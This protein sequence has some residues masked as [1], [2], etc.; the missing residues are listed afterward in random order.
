MQ[1]DEA[2]VGAAFKWT[3]N[4]TTGQRMGEARNRRLAILRAI[5]A[6]D[7]NQRRLEAALRKVERES[8]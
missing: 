2:P 6:I 5:E 4:L 7:S 1:G 8:K 3:A